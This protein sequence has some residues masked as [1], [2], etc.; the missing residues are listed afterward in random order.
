MNLFIIPS[1]YPNPKQPIA[2]IFTK[3][4]AEAI[5]DLRPDINVIVSTWGHDQANIPLRK[6]WEAVNVLQWFLKQQKGVIKTDNK[7]TEVFNPA[8]TWSHHLPFG[9]I[10][11]SL[12]NANRENLR[13]AQKK[14]GKTDL[15][16][17]HVSYPAGYIA[18]I[19]SKEFDIP[20]IITE[21]MSPFPFRSL[22]KRGKPIKAITTAIDQANATVAVSPSLAHRIQSF[23]YQQPAVIPNIVDE[24][25]FHIIPATSAKPFIFFTLCG[26]SAQKGID[27]LLQAIADWKPAQEECEFWIGGQGSMLDT[28]KKLAETLGIGHLVHWLGYISRDA[29]PEYFQKCHA[30]VM[31][32]RHETFG[33]VYAEAIACGKPVIATRCGGP[34]YIVNDVN[35][36][37]VD[38]G[39][40]ASLSKAMQHIHQHAE[41]YQATQIR[42]DFEKRFSR[43]AVV[44]QLHSLYSTILG[45]N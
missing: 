15:I 21:H 14:F 37:L 35:G 26:I 23:G 38:I 18:S 17:A 27:H 5:A 25:R 20:Y 29:A 44:K 4:Q 34:E 1:W 19:L 45:K 42:E 2:G 6:P 24:R 7:I 16:H 11:Q 22:M 30:Y 13:L 33:I 39:N 36:L 40:V 28:Y 9:G 32:S 12:L 43:P 8:I 31:P 10:T 3:E 41:D